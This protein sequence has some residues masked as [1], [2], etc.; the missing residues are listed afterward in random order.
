M[1]GKTRKWTDKEPINMLWTSC[2]GICSAY[3][4]SEHLHP[5]KTRVHFIAHILTALDSLAYLYIED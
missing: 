2:Q 3:S 4:S 5:E 1:A